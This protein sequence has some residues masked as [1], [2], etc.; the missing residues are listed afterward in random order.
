MCALVDFMV[1][2]PRAAAGDYFPIKGLGRKRRTNDYK[3]PV[4][5]GQICVIGAIA[6]A[7]LGGWCVGDIWLHPRHCDR[8]AL[9]DRAAGAR[10]RNKD[11]CARRGRMELGEVSRTERGD[12]GQIWL[13]CQEGMSTSLARH[14]FGLWVDGDTSLYLAYVLVL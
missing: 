7:G 4:R 12:R 1:I 14:I 5:A 10:R 6:A 2:L 3:G 11:T 9:S 8:A 13:C